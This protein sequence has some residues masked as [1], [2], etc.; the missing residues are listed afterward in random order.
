V[1]S[2]PALAAESAAARVEM[3]TIKTRVDIA[4]E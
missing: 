3:P 4:L 2:N 1:T